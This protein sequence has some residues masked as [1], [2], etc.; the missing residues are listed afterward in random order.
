MSAK[1]SSSSASKPRILHML[2]PE[3]N[4]SPF[5]VNMA[6]DAGFEVVIPYGG[7]GANDVTGLV[8]DAIFSRS[9]G[10]ASATGVFLGGWDVNLAAD[11]LERARS[12]LVPPFELSSFADPNGAYTTSAAMIALVQRAFEARATRALA[13][14]RVK[15]FGGG[16]VGLCAGVL[17]AKLDAAVTLVR[18]TGRPESDAVDRFAKRYDVRLA[19]VKGQTVEER[20][21]ALADA[22][23]IL[24]TAKAG[25]QIVDNALLRHAAS[26]VVAADVNAVPPAGI[27][28]V[29]AMSDSAELQTGAGTAAAL[30]ALTIGKLKYSVQRNLFKQML[31]TNS[32]LSLDFMDAL[33][34]ANA[35]AQQG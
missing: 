2:T 20:A 11:M 33:T 18:L 28:G 7:I 1:S 22:E 10:S 12:A 16:P 34:E 29:D 13:G 24:C 25:V 3:P 17:A 23:I 32:A 31:G 4:V 14:A 5:D 30:G 8:Q 6:V 19:S 26:L 15:V 9:P 35:I 27:E 21:G